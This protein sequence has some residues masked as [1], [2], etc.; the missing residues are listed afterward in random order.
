MARATFGH[1]VIS[2]VT[3]PQGPS[4]HSLSSPL[5]THGSHRT[6]EVPGLFGIHFTA[7]VYKTRS[8]VTRNLYVGCV[9]ANH[10]AGEVD[11]SKQPRAAT[12]KEGFQKEIRGEDVGSGLSGG[13]RALPSVL[14][15]WL[16]AAP[17]PSPQP[18]VF[19]GETHWTALLRGMCPP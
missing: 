16:P 9:E 15:S 1:P 2:L 11:Q 17:S 5:N 4:S 18:H 7:W 12:E 10:P 8:R 19:L 6:T 14:A 3:L 13:G